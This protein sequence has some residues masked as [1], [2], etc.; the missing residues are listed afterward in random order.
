MRSSAR[1]DAC[2]Q[3]HS[4]SARRRPSPAFLLRFLS[5]AK[6]MSKR[7]NQLLRVRLEH[8]QIADGFHSTDF[9]VSENLFLR[10]NAIAHR[11][12]DKIVRC[13]SS[14]HNDWQSAGH[15]FEDR[16]GESF[17]TIGM[18][19][20]VAGRVK[21]RNVSC[22][23][24]LIEIDNLRCAR[25]LLDLTNAISQTLTLVNIACSHVFD[26]QSHVIIGA[27][28]LQCMLAVRGLSPCEQWC[29]QQRET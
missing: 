17:A 22:T 26:H 27:K 20:T 14:R 2:C 12:I 6:H 18:H 1:W 3:V 8:P 13:S 5:V 9:T 25:V 28:R 24:I 10:G 4:A 11:V 21:R 16:Q 23:E 15:G 7:L 19:K 29:R